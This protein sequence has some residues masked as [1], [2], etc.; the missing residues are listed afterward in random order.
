MDLRSLEQMRAEFAYK[1]VLDVK[2]PWKIKVKEKG[3]EVVKDISTDIQK[4]Y[5][6]YVKKAPVLILNNGLGQTLAFYLSKLDEPLPLTNDSPMN[7]PYRTIA[8]KIEKRE[9]PEADKYRKA[10]AAA[11]AYLYTHISEWLM[12]NATN[13]VD[14]LRFYMNRSSIEVMRITDEAIALLNWLKRFADAMLEK[15]ESGE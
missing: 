11:Y 9:D 12:G 3:M 15:E 10:E 8:D 7:H 2:K 14:P 6:S 4:K 5:G 1:K 13:G